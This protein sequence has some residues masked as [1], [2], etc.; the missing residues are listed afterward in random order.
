[1]LRPEKK[2]QK[3]GQQKRRRLLIRAANDDRRINVRPCAHEEEIEIHT[4]NQ[5]T[6][7]TTMLLL[8]LLLLW[9]VDDSLY[10]SM[11]TET[12]CKTIRGVMPCLSILCDGFIDGRELERHHCPQDTIR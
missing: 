3:H 11:L 1:V 8:L 6:T 7:T 2:P 12:N 5:S 9:S 4:M 10:L